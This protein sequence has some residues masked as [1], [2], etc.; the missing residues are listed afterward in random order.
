MTNTKL[1]FPWEC[2][3]C[4]GFNRGEPGYRSSWGRVC[5]TCW[6][7]VKERTFEE[8]TVRI[9]LQDNLFKFNT[10]S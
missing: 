5:G 9:I 7:S 6:Q 2:I 3:C 1:A 10:S 4:K 8:I